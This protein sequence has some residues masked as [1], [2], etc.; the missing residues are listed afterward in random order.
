LLGDVAV[1]ALSASLWKFVFKDNLNEFTRGLVKRLC[2]DMI[3]LASC[4]PL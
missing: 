3:L 2:L 4:I 1:F